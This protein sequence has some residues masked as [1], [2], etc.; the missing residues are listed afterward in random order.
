MREEDKMSDFRWAKDTK[1]QWLGYDADALCVGA[2][3]G[4][5]I[6]IVCFYIVLAIYL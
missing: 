2:M 1:E 3:L 4:A 6:C 5:G